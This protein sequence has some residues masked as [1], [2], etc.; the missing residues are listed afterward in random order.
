MI[1][2]IISPFNYS[3]DG[4]T[5]IDAIKKFIKLNHDL[6]INKMIIEDRQKYYQANINYYNNNMGRRK[7]GIDTFPSNYIPIIN[8]KSPF[9]TFIKIS[10][11]KSE[12]NKDDNETIEKKIIVPMSMPYIEGQNNYPFRMP[13]YIPTVVTVSK[14]KDDNGDDNNK[15]NEQDNEKSNIK[16]IFPLQR[17]Y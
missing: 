16:F 4:T 12:N 3:I 17:R 6:N 2:K 9:E 5:H 15:D 11:D 7:V 10:N 14:N 8:P 13:N 1:Y